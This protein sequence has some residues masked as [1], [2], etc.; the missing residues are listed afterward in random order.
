MS[1][2]NVNLMFIE[3]RDPELFTA[4]IALVSHTSMIL[5]L[6]AAPQQDAALTSV[7]LALVEHALAQIKASLP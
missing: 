2:N 1:P 5:E 7:E 3:K 4:A 6:L